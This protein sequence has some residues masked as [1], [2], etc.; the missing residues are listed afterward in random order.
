[1]PLLSP[2]LSPLVIKQPCGIGTI[3]DAVKEY[4]VGKMRCIKNS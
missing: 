3:T 2:L 4:R 1:M